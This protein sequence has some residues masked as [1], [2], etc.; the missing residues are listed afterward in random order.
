MA[1]PYPPTIKIAK[2]YPHLDTCPP[3]TFL[4]ATMVTGRFFPV[5]IPALKITEKIC[6]KI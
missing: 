1:A 2:D 3:R 4:R 6:I 5:A